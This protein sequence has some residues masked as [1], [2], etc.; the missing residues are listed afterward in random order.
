MRSLSGNVA[1]GRSRKL[2]SVTGRCET[3]EKET[4]V[5]ILPACVRRWQ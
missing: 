2:E 4:L 5:E 3:G 1:R